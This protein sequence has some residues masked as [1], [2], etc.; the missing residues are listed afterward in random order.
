M[1]IEDAFTIIGKYGRFQCYCH[2]ILILAQVFLA[3]QMVLMSIIGYTPDKI[4]NSRGKIETTQNTIISEWDLYSNEKTVVSFIQ[5]LYMFGVLLGNL[6]FGELADSYGRKAVYSK[7]F[8]LFI[9]TSFIT[10]FA[11]NHVVLGAIRFFVGVFLGGVGLISFVQAQELLGSSMWTI[12][13]C[14]IPA[15]FAIGLAILAEIG[16]YVTDWRNVCLITSLPGFALWL[17]YIP[18]PE[19]PRW[20]YSK[21]KVAESQE[22]MRYM[23]SKNGVISQTPLNLK[24][25]LD[26]DDKKKDKKSNQHQQGIKSLFTS[27]QVLVRTLVMGFVWFTSSFV[28]YGLTMNS[29]KLSSDRFTSLALMGVVELPAAALCAVVITRPW[30]GRKRSLMGSLLLASVACSA[31][32]FCDETTSKDEASS[33]N[34]KLVLALI[35]K[36]AITFTFNT[37]YI[38]ASEL[39]PTIIRNVGVGFSSVC[40]RVGGILSSFIPSLTAVSSKLPFVMFSAFCLIGALITMAIPETLNCKV[41]DTIEDL[42]GGATGGKYTRVGADINDDEDA[43]DVDMFDDKVRLL[44][45]TSM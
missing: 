41:P 39:F 7:V 35:G 23:A 21:G 9:F 36:L 27:R 44:A 38:Y 4:T 12:S 11:N 13:G 34:A 19:S 2:V 6:V 20:L 22:V 32:L 26:A 10:T 1:D 16:R 8:F 43:A 24:P 37:I 14:I 28:Y 17:L 3:F 45:D 33:W 30:A 31:V 15:F 29:G 42:E 18:V 25:K 5:S 40:A